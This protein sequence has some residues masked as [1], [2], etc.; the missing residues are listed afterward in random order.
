MEVQAALGTL[1]FFG[2]PDVDY[3]KYLKL[4][5]PEY[6]SEI[7]RLEF[8]LSV[9]RNIYMGILENKKFSFFFEKLLYLTGEYKFLT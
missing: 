4:F 1:N 2:L 8:R 3:L 5:C 7:E 9:K 6:K